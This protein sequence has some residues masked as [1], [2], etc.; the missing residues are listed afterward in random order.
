MKILDKRWKIIL[1]GCSGLGVNMLN[2]IVGSYLCSALIADGFD[3][4]VENWTYFNRNLVIIGV[5]MA[6]SFAV[7][8]LDGFIDIPF[9]SFTDNLRTKWGR[10]RPAILIG[11]IP[12]LLSYCLFLVPLN[13]EA[14]LLNTLWFSLVLGIFYCTYTLTMLTFYA[15]FSEIVASDKDRVLLSNVKSICDVV[16]F[17]LSFVLVPLFVDTLRVNIRLVALIFLPLAA[18]MLIP[19]F[20]IREKST[21]DGVYTLSG[22]KQERLTV[23]QSFTYS[24]RNKPFLFWLFVLSTMN[25]G[26]QLFLSG[27]N[28]FFSNTSVSMALVMPAAF[29]PIPFTLI[30]YNKI[31]KRKGLR[32]A[33]QY[34]LLVFSVGMTLM[35]F[36]RYMPE[37]VMLP[38]ALV[39]A[40]TTSFAI[41][42]FFSVSYTVPAQ[43]AAEENERSAVCAS[44]MYFAVQGIFEAVAAG[45]GSRIILNLL[46]SIDCV[47]LLPLIV[48]GCCM[49][50]FVMAFFLPQSI[51]RIGKRQELA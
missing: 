2:M 8:V 32:F 43:L 10:R 28:E 11:Y 30:L 35:F 12:M 38:M 1:Y 21:K 27:I 26:M 33:Y 40:V 19:F 7:K 22:V 17:S 20:L 45:I 46:K 4:N 44:S 6:L 3:K 42:A 25:I 31:I 41:G 34:C 5:W 16:Y 37:A 29:A 47:I 13:K 50:A 15:T 9:S 39:A 24:F 48:S 18:T 23:L 49:A 51:A 14:S 36:T